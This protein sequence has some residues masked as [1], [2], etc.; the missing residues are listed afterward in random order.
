[1]SQKKASRPDLLL[2]LSLLFVIILYPLL[3]HVRAGRLIVGFLIFLP[4][5]F[6]TVEMSQLKHWGRRSL[7]LVGCILALSVAEAVAPRPVF[8]SAK[9]ALVAAFLVLSVSALFSYLW[10]T[11]VVTTNHL[12]TATS[13]YFLLAFLWFATYSAI[14]AIYPGAFLHS[15]GRQLDRPSDL[16]YFSFITLTTAG[17]GDILPA[18]GEVRILAALEASTGVLYVA[19]MIALLV[20]AYRQPHD[21]TS[22][23]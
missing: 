7:L 1:M 4:L 13:I 16:L 20:S 12:Y 8:D 3:E 17:Y 5:S 6:A 18:S 2:L 21:P 9:W 19:I 23:T 10:T 14:E 15:G 22:R 11:Q